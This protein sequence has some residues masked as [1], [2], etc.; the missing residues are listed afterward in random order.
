M[1]KILALFIIASLLFGLWWSGYSE[2]KNIWNGFL[3]ILCCIVFGGIGGLLG[4][5]ITKSFEK[6][7]PE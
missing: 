2:T 4:I 5:F 7:S 6:K 3:Y 1:R